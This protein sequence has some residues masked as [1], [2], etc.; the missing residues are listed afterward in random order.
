MNSFELKP[1]RLVQQKIIELLTPDEFYEAQAVTEVAGHV[2]VA[3]YDG[4]DLNL[5]TYAWDELLDKY[6]R[7]T[8]L[9][10]SWISNGYDPDAAF[11]DAWLEVVG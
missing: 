6:A 8:E 9:A 3:Q 4:H 10:A 11:H 1:N 7:A 2:V 5:R